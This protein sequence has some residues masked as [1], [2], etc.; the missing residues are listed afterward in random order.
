MHSFCKIKFFKKSYEFFSILKF[1]Q[2]LG[3]IKIKIKILNQKFRKGNTLGSPH[4]FFK[5][6]C[7]A[8]GVAP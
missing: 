7:M 2:D 8:M 3:V 1:S 4:I 6:N 5:I